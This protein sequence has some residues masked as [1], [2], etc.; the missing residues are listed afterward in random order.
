MSEEAQMKLV[1]AFIQYTPGDVCALLTVI[2]LFLFALAT[3]IARYVV[4]SKVGW[5]PEVKQE[6]Y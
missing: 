4:I 5:P 2:F 3:M 6:Y 1:E